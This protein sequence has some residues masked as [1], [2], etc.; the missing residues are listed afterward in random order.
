VTWQTLY[1]DTTE[2]NGEWI[3]AGKLHSATR[4]LPFPWRGE[5]A[6]ASEREGVNTSASLAMRVTAA[7]PTPRTFRCATSP[8]QGEVK[9]ESRSRD[10]FYT[11]A[12]PS[13]CL[14]SSPPDLIRWSMQSSSR[15][16]LG[17]K[18]LAGFTA[19]W[20]AGSS[21]AMTKEMVGK[22]ERKRRKNRKQNAD[23]RNGVFAGSIGPGRA[24]KRQA[25][26]YRRSTAVLSP[27]ESFIARDAASGHASWD[28]VDSALSFE[29]ALPAP[30]C[31][32]PANAPRTPVIVPAG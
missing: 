18:R 26:I 7:H 13:H 25:H 21:P 5:V 20:I 22:N 19:V 16:M 30:A 17:G 2:R 27:K 23:R 15:Q 1:A 24:C 3:A 29:R 14:E 10:A 6:S 9:I 11:R 4:S 8:P 12:M 31:P 32:S 28:V